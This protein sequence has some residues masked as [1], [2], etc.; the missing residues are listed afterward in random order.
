MTPQIAVLRKGSTLNCHTCQN[1]AVVEKTGT[2][3][4]GWIIIKVENTM[5]ICCPTHDPIVR[6]A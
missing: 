6:V 4:T 3:P 2:L 5:Y 1:S